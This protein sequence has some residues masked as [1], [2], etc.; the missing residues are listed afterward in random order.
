MTAMQGARRVRRIRMTCAG[1]AAATWMLSGCMS[2]GAVSPVADSGPLQQ[3]VAALRLRAQA[4]R[5][6]DDIKRLQRAYG[7]YIDAGQ[8][9]Q[10]ADLFARDATLEIGLDGYSAARIA[11]ASTSGRWAAATKASRPARSTNTCS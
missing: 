7:Y 8:W 9:D 3:S 1:L 5:D 4:L 6:I 11:S 2:G 10:V